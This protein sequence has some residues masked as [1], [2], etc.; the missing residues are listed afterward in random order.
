M[1]TL[2]GCTTNQNPSTHARQT[3]QEHAVPF[4]LRVVLGAVLHLNVSP[5]HFTNCNSHFTTGCINNQ[6]PCATD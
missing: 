2:L 1:T 3:D 6:N 4:G 5:K